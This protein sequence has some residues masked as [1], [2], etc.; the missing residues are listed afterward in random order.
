MPC[1]SGYT[2]QESRSLTEFINLIINLS[3]D[4]FTNTK[5]PCTT[6]DASKVL[7]VYDPIRHGVVGLDAQAFISLRIRCAGNERGARHP[8]ATQGT[9]EL[10]T[11]WFPS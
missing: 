9:L 5:L 2:R 10:Q 3:T 6:N 7:T 1:K 8:L 4:K 11:A